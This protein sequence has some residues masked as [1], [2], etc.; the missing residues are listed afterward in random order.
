MPDRFHARCERDEVALRDR[1]T[2]E[3]PDRTFLDR[4]ADEL[5]RLAQEAKSAGPPEGAPPGWGVASNGVLVAAAMALRTGRAIGL[6]VGSGYAYEAAGL[7]RRLGEITQH[8]A[9]CAQDPSGDYARRWGAGAGAA[10][11][12]SSAYVRGVSDPASIREKWLWLSNMEHATA[13]PYLSLMCAHD[14][15]GEVV[16]PVAPARHAAADTQALSSAA[17]DLGRTAAAI[18]KAHPHVDDGPTLALARE[19]QL[20]QAA[21]EDRVNAWVAAREQE[22]ADHEREDG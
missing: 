21:S 14:E 19:M 15:H 17:W 22:I 9:S 13:G 4:A 3:L 10:G 11:K 12:A 20:Q 18:C 8:A 6:L 2:H 16:H 5:F 7:V 1:A